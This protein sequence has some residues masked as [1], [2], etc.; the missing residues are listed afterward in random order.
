[1]DNGKDP[2]LSSRCWWFTT[3]VLMNHPTSCSWHLHETLVFPM[4]TTNSLLAT[5]ERLPQCNLQLVLWYRKRVKTLTVYT[6]TVVYMV[7]FMNS[8]ANRYRLYSIPAICISKFFWNTAISSLILW[9]NLLTL[10]SGL[11]SISSRSVITVTLVCLVDLMVIYSP[12]AGDLL[13][14][15]YPPSP[16]WSTIS[17]ATRVGQITSTANC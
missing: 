6:M 14:A 3:H 15:C 1:M 13:F 8:Y 7:Q 16:K 11:T 12:R 9:F 2:Y 4:V 10:M 17:I 5:F